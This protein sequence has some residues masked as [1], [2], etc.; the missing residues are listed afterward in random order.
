[1]G[2]GLLPHSMRSATSCSSSSPIFIISSADRD[3]TGADGAAG[4]G[5]G[6]S[7]TGA[8]EAKS[9]DKA[10]VG[11]FGAAGGAPRPASS[12]INVCIAGSTGSGIAGGGDGISSAGCANGSSTGGG[13]GGAIA[14]GMGG[15]DGTP[16]PA[17]SA[18][19]FC[20]AD[21]AIPGTSVEGAVAS[22][23]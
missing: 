10:D 4:A 5:V 14:S 13:G 22:A 3:G 2:G 21:W 12:A 18:I 17:S 9:D 1:M 11:V 20:I 16:R 8:A 6:A 7:G 23:G 19:K 15:A